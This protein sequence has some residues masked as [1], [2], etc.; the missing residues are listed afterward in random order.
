MR[1]TYDGILLILLAEFV[2]AVGSSTF[3]AFLACLG[4]M[5]LF[6]GEWYIGIIAVYGLANFFLIRFVF[7]RFWASLSKRQDQDG[8]EMNGAFIVSDSSSAALS[9]DA[10][11]ARKQA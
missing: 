3:I 5:I 11:G 1:K 8:S 7:N 10:N 4:C 9:T 2:V 6:G